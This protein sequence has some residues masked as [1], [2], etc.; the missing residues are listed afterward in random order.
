MS[1]YLVTGATGF[2]GSHLV[3]GL[4]S[5][6]HQVVALV[7][8]P[9]PELQRDG[10]QQL[11]GDVL[12][13]ASVAKA[14]A[15]CT[16]LFHCAG[17]VSRDAADTATMMQV[18][19]Q[20]TAITLDAA[21][22]AGIRRVVVASTSGTVAVSTEAVAQNEDAPTPNGLIG[23]WP[24]YRSKLYAEKAALDRNGADF[25]VICVNPSLLLGPG[26]LRG[27]ST[28]DVRQFLEK[29]VQAVPA[30][31][32]S[33]VDARDAASALIAAME[34]G[35]AG[36]RYLVSA[37][38]CTVREF[39]GKL[40]RVSGVKAPWL[41]MPKSPELAKQAVRL[42]DKVVDRFGGKQPV[43][44]ETVDVAQHFWYVDWAKAERE[45]GFKPRDPMATLRETVEDLRAR[46]VVWPAPPAKGAA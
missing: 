12:D 22:S 25:E 20:G 21:K 17:M 11:Q 34:R 18:H 13:A 9:S 40:E 30:G 45:L 33:F 32:V 19:V 29:Q 3:S 14:A 31:G 10:V 23:R 46:G 43:S 28:G 27:S 37:C 8:T 38:N 35:R 41:P 2:L 26:D 44:E 39:F 16:G 4:L 15:G 7:R 1:K 36:Q 42:L 24:Y 5:G 6:G